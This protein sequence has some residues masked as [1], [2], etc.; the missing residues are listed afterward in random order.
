MRKT[1]LA[2]LGLTLAC[3]VAWAEDGPGLPRDATFS[4]LITT[5][6]AIEGLTG[7]DQGNLYTTGRVTSPC[8]VWR[9]SLSSPSLVTVG[10]IPATCSPSGITFDAKGDLFVVDNDK[11]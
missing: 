3:S 9:I 4:T 7:D 8:P 10:N 1:T 11:V 5:P 6:F 2:L